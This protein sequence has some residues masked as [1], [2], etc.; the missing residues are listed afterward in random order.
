MFLS[1]IE[2]GRF[3]YWG[4][5]PSAGESPPSEAAAISPKSSALPMTDCSWFWRQAE[6]CAYEVPPDGRFDLDL[7]WGVPP[8]HRTDVPGGRLHPTRTGASTLRPTHDD[9]LLSAAL[10]AEFDRLLR[11]GD[12]RLGAA[13]SEVIDGESPWD[14]KNL[15]F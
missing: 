9:R 3:K 6:A 10:I 15:F 14:P 7:R 1:L 11:A 4:Y 5:D 12:L 8:T 2:T 13:R